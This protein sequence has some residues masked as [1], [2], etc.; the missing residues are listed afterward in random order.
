MHDDMS[1]KPCDNCTIIMVNYADLWLMH[2]HVASLLDGTRLELRELKARSTL[3]G[4]CTTYPLLRSDLEA[5]AIKIKDL[6]HK[7][8]HSS[9]Y[10][11]LSHSCDKCGSLKGKLF[12]ATKENTEL[13]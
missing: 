11:I 3:L 5:S 7:L 12:H 1:V 2:S 8:D 13:Q 9:R 10:S 6:K 4:A